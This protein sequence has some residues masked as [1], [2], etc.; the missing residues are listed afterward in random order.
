MRWR[1]ALVSP[2][3]TSHPVVTLA[4]LPALMAELAQRIR[5]TDFRPD[6]LVYVEEGARLPAEAL[7]RELALKA[8][9]V[10]ARRRGHGLKKR[11]A[12]LVMLLPRAVTNALRR[13]EER[14]R[15]HAQGDRELA[16][17]HECDWTGR[18]ILLLDDAAD[19][20]GTLRAVKADLL[21][22]GVE[23]TRLRTAVLTATT[24]A[25]RSQADFYVLE[26]N[27]VLPWSPDSNERKRAQALMAAMKLAGP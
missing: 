2:I 19:T 5:A 9:P 20:G 24:P 11:L 14:S 22:R 4:E 16:W 25:G 26:R 21:R 6:I 7:C 18:R 1:P 13:I 27:C 3:P 15:I 10:V 17:P 8:V 23:V 12:P